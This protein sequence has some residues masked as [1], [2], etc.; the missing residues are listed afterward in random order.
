MINLYDEI[1]LIKSHLFQLKEFKQS[2]IINKKNTR[3]FSLRD[4]NDY[5]NYFNDDDNLFS[6]KKNNHLRVAFFYPIMQFLDV[7]DMLNLSLVNK[8]FYFFIHSIFFYKFRT[9][10]YY[11]QRKQIY[12]DNLNKLKKVNTS[13]NS[14]NNNKSFFSKLTGAFTYLAPVCDYSVNRQEKMTLQHIQDKIAIHE[15]LLKEKIEHIQISEE[16]NEI[17]KK[18]NIIVEQ[19]MKKSSDDRAIERIKREGVEKNYRE[20]K[21]E[22][23]I[24][25]KEI[26]KL[27][28][29]NKEL[30]KAE[31]NDKMKLNLLKNYVTNNFDKPKV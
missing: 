27:S 16:V 18:I 14:Q 9:Q 24:I 23:D 28:K 22:V 4:D 1:S 12:V 6:L 3:K 19:R 21:N 31:I 17:R 8:D 10:I 15:Q 13:S 11:F 29:K 30:E 2:A 20:I 25:K 7:K 26:E 5:K